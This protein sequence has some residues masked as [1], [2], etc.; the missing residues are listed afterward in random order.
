MKE[1]AIIREESLLQDSFWSFRSVLMNCVTIHSPVE[2]LQKPMDAEVQCVNFKHFHICNFHIGIYSKLSFDV[3]FSN[4]NVLEMF[5]EVHSRHQSRMN[6][7]WGMDN[8][9]LIKPL[10]QGSAWRLFTYEVSF[11]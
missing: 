1:A 11:L 3:N 10:P 7:A 2:K 9:L 8:I 5:L 4:G 6:Q